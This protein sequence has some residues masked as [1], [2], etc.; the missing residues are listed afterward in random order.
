MGEV[1][2]VSTGAPP[3]PMPAPRGSQN[4]HSGRPEA[5]RFWA[6][7]RA[8]AGVARPASV[9][10]HLVLLLAGQAVPRAEGPCEPAPA[11]G[12]RALGAATGASSRLGPVREGQPGRGGEGQKT[13]ILRVDTQ[14][15]CPGDRRSPQVC[16]SSGRW[17]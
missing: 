16:K 2:G 9:V 7:R 6:A 11:S 5:R 14:E 1:H 17:G 12:P 15:G 13:V 10:E 8:A 3:Q 4:A